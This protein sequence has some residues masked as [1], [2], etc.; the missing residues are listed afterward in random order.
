[1]GIFST[2]PE[3]IK[4]G[5]DYLRIIAISYLITGISNT[6]LCVLRCTEQA[7]APLVI[8][9]CSL[10]L[11]TVLN[12]LLIFGKFG[13]PVMGVKGAAL[14]TVIAR[15]FEFTCAIIFTFALDKRKVFKIK[16]LIQIRVSIIK[17]YIKYGIPAFLNDFIWGIG[18]SGHAVILGRMGADAVAAYTATNMAERFAFIIINGFGA[19]TAVIVG[20]ELGADNIE[21]TKKHCKYMLRIAML[22]GIVMAAI[23]LTIIPLFLK[24]FNFTAETLTI[25]HYM[26]LVMSVLILVKSMNYTIT[27]GFLRSGGDVKISAYVDNLTLFLISLPLGY[28]MAFVLH[29]PAYLVYLA[30]MSDEISKVFIYFKRYKSY[31][32][33]KNITI[34]F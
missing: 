30:L 34:A 33:A 23:S 8:N 24:L 1:M 15:F 28:I 19:A 17:E 22:L 25:S 12:Y 13:F 11:N 9:C 3:L 16:Y 14:A 26:I 21:Q 2:D 4:L 18:I 20:K 31:K 27:M 6:F 32:W 7:K 5:S 29:A 10:V